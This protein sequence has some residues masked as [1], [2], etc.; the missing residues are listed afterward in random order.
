MR[1]ARYLHKA[2]GRELNVIYKFGNTL[3]YINF[4]L[5][6]GTWIG[7]GRNVVWAPLNFCITRRQE[8]Y[9]Y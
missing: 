6:I 8:K 5:P 9:V 4:I 3:C 7:N 1:F 2:V